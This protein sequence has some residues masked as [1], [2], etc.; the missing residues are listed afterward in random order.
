MAQIAGKA[1]LIS[2]F[3]GGAIFSAAEMPYPP[4]ICRPMIAMAR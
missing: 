4:S 3:L 2:A 1:K